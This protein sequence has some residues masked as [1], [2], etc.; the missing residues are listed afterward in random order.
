MARVRRFRGGRRTRG[1]TGLAD[2]ALGVAG[3]GNEHVGSGAPGFARAGTASRSSF[4]FRDAKKC[5]G[6]ATCQTRAAARHTPMSTPCPQ[7]C[8]GLGWSCT[9]PLTVSWHAYRWSMSNSGPS[10][11]WCWPGF[12]Q[13]ANWPLDVINTRRPYTGLCLP[14]GKSSRHPT[15]SGGHPPAIRRWC[16][17]NSILRSWNNAKN[18]SCH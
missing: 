17:R 2:A 15:E 11:N 4:N 16:A 7:P 8:P 9:M 6:Q 3:R 5:L 10:G 13:R 14:W 12:V 18:S 1:R